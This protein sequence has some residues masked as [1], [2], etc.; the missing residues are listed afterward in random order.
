M[1]QVEIVLSQSMQPAAGNEKAVR[2][3]GGTVAEC[4][5][6]LVTRFPD[7]K[8]LVFDKKGKLYGYLEIFINKKSAY[9]GELARPVSDGDKLHI[10]NIIA[11]G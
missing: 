7:L 11:G 1:M 9:P 3:S 8:S 4:L 10:V 2:V 5:D 6:A